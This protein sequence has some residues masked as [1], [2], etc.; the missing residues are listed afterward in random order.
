[1]K[2]KLNFSDSEDSVLDDVSDEEVSFD[3]ITEEPEE[4]IEP[5]AM[6]TESNNNKNK[7]Y[8]LEQSNNASVLY[9][10]N[11]IS[12]INQ[13]WSDSQGARV[14]QP[15]QSWKKVKSSIDYFKVFICSE[16]LT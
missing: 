1:M 5:I 11:K 8:C 16:I 3:E 9:L 6:S 15:I 12:E 10:S 14:T 4:A 2:N 13:N 7:D